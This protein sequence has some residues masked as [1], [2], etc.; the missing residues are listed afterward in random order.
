M[1]SIDL[2]SQPHSPLFNALEATLMLYEN[3]GYGPRIHM[4]QK[5]PQALALLNPLL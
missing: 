5:L 2:R 1:A 3:T 4:P